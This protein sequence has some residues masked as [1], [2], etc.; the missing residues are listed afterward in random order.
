MCLLHALT[1]DQVQ[2][3]EKIMLKAIET[4]G[5]HGR[6]KAIE[7]LIQ[8]MAESDNPLVKDKHTT[9]QTLTRWIIIGGRC[10]FGGSDVGS[11][12]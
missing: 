9:A 11:P 3:K 1:T 7:R 10:C 4:K 2:S 5:S 8:H 6:A 12:E